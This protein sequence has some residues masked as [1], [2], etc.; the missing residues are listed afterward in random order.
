MGQHCRQFMSWTKEQWKPCTSYIGIIIMLKKCDIIYYM[1]HVSRFK[2]I[3]KCTLKYYLH[4]K[5]DLLQMVKLLNIYVI[6][7]G[8]K[9]ICFHFYVNLG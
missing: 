7:S 1:L 5:V 4:I 3:F 6:L 9:Q 2:H 8:L